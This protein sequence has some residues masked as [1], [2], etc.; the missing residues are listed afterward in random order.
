LCDTFMR[1][2][3]DV[4]TNTPKL[5]ADNIDDISDKTMAAMGVLKTLGTLVLNL[6]GSPEVVFSL[7]AVVYPVIRFVL[8]QHV[9]DL[10]DEAFEILDCCLFAVKTVSPNAW[11]LFGAIYECFKSDGIDFIEEMLPSLD[12]YVSYG[13][14][15]IAATSELQARLFDVVETVMKSDRVGEGDRT[16]AC[17]LAEAIMLHGRGKVDGM[18]PGF[19]GLAAAYLLADDAIK[20][21]QFRVHVLEIVLNALYYNPAI[22]L[23]VLEQYQWTDGVFTRLLQSVDRFTRVH[24]KKLLILG[25]TAILGVPAAQL[26][27]S[28]QGGLSQLFAGVLQSFQSLGK[29]IEAREALE[30]M[31]EG[32]D[33]DGDFD[34]ASNDFEWDGGSDID[35]DDGVFADDDDA[36]E[37]HGQSLRDLAGRAAAALGSAAGDIGEFELGSG[38]DDDDDDEEDDDFDAALEEEYALE[39]PIEQINLYIHLQD[40]LAEVQSTNGAVYDAIFGSLNAE[41]TQLVQA[42]MDEATAQRAQ[43][44]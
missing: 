14:D 31:Y 30:K 21:A 39:S 1:V 4:V 32:D 43:Q 44:A 29:A 8:E 27:P 15:V 7:E 19:L 26:P 20:T 3:G 24:D 10:Y 33:L 25:L 38:D 9:V 6:E 40:K 35:A 16:C 36:D 13:M 12:N 5:T 23:G 37:A 42:L 18:I 17:K 2:M 34:G 28:L 22:A 11:G 41:S